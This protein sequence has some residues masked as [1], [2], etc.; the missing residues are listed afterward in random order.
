MEHPEI[1][2]VSPCNPDC[3]PS[4]CNPQTPLYYLPLGCLGSARNFQ[5]GIF[6]SRLEGQE[7][8][9]LTHNCRL[10]ILLWN[11]HRPRLQTD[12]APPRSLASSP[13]GKAVSLL[14]HISESCGVRKTGRLIG[15]NK[16]T[17]M[18]Y[19]RLA[20]EHAKMLHD[21]LVSFSPGDS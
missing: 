3:L 5:S 2:E 10:L 17:V 13:L 1:Q 14:D 15:V 11:G 20:G 7:P 9:Y 8:S 4:I 18:R 12:A 16:N 19:S 6:P 21:E